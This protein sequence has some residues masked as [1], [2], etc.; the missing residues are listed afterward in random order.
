MDYEFHA[1]VRLPSPL[2]P[3]IVL[4]P[5]DEHKLPYSTWREGLA[6]NRDKLSVE[7]PNCFPRAPEALVP[8]ASQTPSL[9]RTS[10]VDTGHCNP[11]PVSP[12]LKYQNA[13]ADRDLLNDRFR[14]PR[15]DPTAPGTF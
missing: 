1:Q 12:Q 4:S 6:Q 15:S 2:V 7:S 9:Y 3:L 8:R 11:R 5:V 13:P 14:S 10:N